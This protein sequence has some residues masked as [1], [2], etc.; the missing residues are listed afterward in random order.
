[1]KLA[2]LLPKSQGARRLL[3]G[4]SVGYWFLALTAGGL[5]Y[6]D[7]SDSFN[8]TSGHRQ[9]ILVESANGQKLSQ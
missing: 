2:G 8:G 7:Q 3:A 9:E 1:M 6:Q 5:A 4:L